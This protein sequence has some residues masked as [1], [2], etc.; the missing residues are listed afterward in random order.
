[1]R[2]EEFDAA[3]DLASGQWIDVEVLMRRRAVARAGT[4]SGDPEE[5]RRGTHPP[6]RERERERVR[7]P[8]G[9]GSCGTL[10]GWCRDRGVVATSAARVATQGVTGQASSLSS[11]RPQLGADPGPDQRRFREG[12]LPLPALPIV[13]T[14]ASQV[15][16]LRGRRQAA[17]LDLRFG[18]ARFSATTARSASF[19]DLESGNSAASSGSS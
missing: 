10:D 9:G 18:N 15:G 14:P 1:M 7:L 6:D 13:P 11:M 17:L 19:T 16:G 5:K 3:L 12:G 4:A 2:L 8:Y